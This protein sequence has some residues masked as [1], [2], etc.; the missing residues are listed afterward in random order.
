MFSDEGAGGHV[1]RS[2]ADT[3]CHMDSSLHTRCQLDSLLPSVNGHRSNQK[4]SCTSMYE[5]WHSFIHLKTSTSGSNCPPVAWSSLANSSQHVPHHWEFLSLQWFLWHHNHW[6]QSLLLG[7]NTA[8]VCAGQNASAVLWTPCLVGAV[9][10]GHNSHSWREMVTFQ[11]P[12]DYRIWPCMLSIP[13][14]WCPWMCMH[15]TLQ[16]VSWASW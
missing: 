9:T 13:R 12:G 3:Q 8:E 15:G 10:P 2:S 14:I 7:F 16:C 1:S 5:C 4:F 11:V 6:L